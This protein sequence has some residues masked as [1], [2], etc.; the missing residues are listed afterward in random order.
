MPRIQNGNHFSDTFEIALKHLLEIVAS[1]AALF[2]Q[3]SVLIVCE[4]TH[5]EVTWTNQALLKHLQSTLHLCSGAA[6]PLSLSI[7][8]P[9]LLHCVQG[10]W[11]PQPGLEVPHIVSGKKGR[12]KVEQA[13]M[14]SYGFLAPDFW[15]APWQTSSSFGTS[16]VVSPTWQLLWSQVRRKTAQQDTTGFLQNG[17][18]CF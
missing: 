17:T 3:D 18:T 5:E 1:S 12:P 15:R 13:R 14:T 2:D 16:K 9:G 6:G 10:S 8:Q 11:K 7:G 4:E